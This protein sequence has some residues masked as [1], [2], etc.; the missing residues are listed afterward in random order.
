MARLPTA[1]L[2]AE[3]PLVNP[4]PLPLPSVEDAVL[5]HRAQRG[6]VWAREAIFRKHVGYVN[7]LS[8]RLVR[9]RSEAEDVVQDTFLAAFRR[10]E[11]L[12]D[13]GRLRG[14]L[15][16]IAVHH[17]HRRFRRRRWLRFVGLGLPGESLSLDQLA[18]GTIDTELRDALIHVDAIVSRLPEEVRAAWIL[19]YVEGYT[20]DEIC[21]AS[22][23]SL[24]TAKRRVERA[25]SLVRGQVEIEEGGQ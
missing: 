22:G 11:Q 5:V 25:Q 13:P 24:A 17:A 10:L 3:P 23:C 2:P 8:L 14:W 12:S 21:V 18:S 9:D 4:T 16:S 6:E 20:F 15:G 19:R 1:L 7:A